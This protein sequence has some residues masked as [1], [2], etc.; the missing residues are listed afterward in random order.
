MTLQPS[1][2]RKILSRVKPHRKQEETK[3][4]ATWAIPNQFERQ[5]DHNHPK[6]LV[7]CQPEARG[8]REGS[9]LGRHRHVFHAPISV[10][11]R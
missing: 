5:P 7:E 11:D 9:G 2:E 1:I 8:R 10:H 3:R 6:C 4:H